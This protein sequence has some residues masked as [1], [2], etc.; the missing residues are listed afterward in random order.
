MQRNDD[1][2]L[3]HRRP[4]PGAPVTIT[5]QVLP[6]T[7]GIISNTAQVSANEWDASLA[8]NHSVYALKVR[9]NFQSFLPLIKR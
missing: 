6:G 9:K 2:G 8:N 7:V 5:I 3:R 1:P 4:G